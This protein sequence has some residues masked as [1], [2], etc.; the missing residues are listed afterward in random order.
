MNQPFEHATSIEVVEKKHIEYTHTPLQ[1][2]Y[3]IMTFFLFLAIMFVVIS[4][5]ID[6]IKDRKAKRI[7]NVQ[8]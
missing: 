7:F 4:G 8:T 2:P 6:K 5:Y 1:W 3:M